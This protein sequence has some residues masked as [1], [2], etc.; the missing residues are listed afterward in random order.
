M[1]TA[2]TVEML[3]RLGRVIAIYMITMGLTDITVTEADIREA[4]AT[5]DGGGLATEIHDDRIT[6]RL[7][8]K[9]ENE[10]LKMQVGRAQ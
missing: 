5:L 1:S 7:L 10:L 9:A 4:A 3:E 8:S 6:L 2:D